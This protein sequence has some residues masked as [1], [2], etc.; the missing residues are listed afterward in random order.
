MQV[1]ATL[2]IALFALI[3]VASA[4]RGGHGRPLYVKNAQLIADMSIDTDDIPPNLLMN[5]K[6]D[7]KK[8]NWRRSISGIFDA[9]PRIHESRWTRGGPF[10]RPMVVEEFLSSH[11]T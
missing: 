2:L 9:T 7:T 6:K 10:V 11:Q 1:L 4:F 8:N 5:F 3:A